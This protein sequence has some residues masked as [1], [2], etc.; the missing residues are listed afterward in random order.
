MF[1]ENTC[2][3][4]INSMNS[5]IRV[6]ALGNLLVFIKGVIYEARNSNFN[7]DKTVKQ[8]QHIQDV[9]RQNVC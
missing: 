3:E 5:I 9:T 6:R 8:Q 1:Y 4:I 7:L 2:I